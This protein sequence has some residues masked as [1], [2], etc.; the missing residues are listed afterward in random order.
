M[1]REQSIL[2]KLDTYFK[3]EDKLFQH[4]VLGYRIDFYVPKYKVAIE[5]NELGHCTRNIKS[6]IEKQSKIKKELGC[7]FIRIDPSRENFVQ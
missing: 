2:T 1:T 5:V 6:D 3:T 4:Y 7:K